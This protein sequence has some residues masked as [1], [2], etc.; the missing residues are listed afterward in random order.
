M[1]KNTM[2]INKAF[3]ATVRKFKHC[4]ISKYFWYGKANKV[5]YNIAFWIFFKYDSDLSLN[6]ANGTTKDIELFLFSKMLELGYPKMAF[7]ENMV[8]YD[9]LFVIVAGEKVRDTRPLKR[10]TL[11]MFGSSETVKRD[12]KG[13]YYLYTK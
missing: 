5:P 2:I 13:D 3:K 7:E 4:N 1:F 11:L 9:K 12:Y 8:N 10:T 6:S